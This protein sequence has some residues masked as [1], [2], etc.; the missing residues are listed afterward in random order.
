[1]ANDGRGVNPA[2]HLATLLSCLGGSKE[3][4]YKLVHRKHWKLGTLTEDPDAVFQEIKNRR[5][6]FTE[7]PMGK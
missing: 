3:N 2:E 6:K 1:M 5:V 7:S 4:V